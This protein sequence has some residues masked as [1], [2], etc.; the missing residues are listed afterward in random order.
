MGYIISSSADIAIYESGTFNIDTLKTSNE[1]DIK[2]EYYIDNVL[3]WSGFVVPNFFSR[4]IGTPAIV[5]MVASDR[6]GSLK[7]QTLSGLPAMV[8]LSS[9]VSSCLSK[10]VLSLPIN[11]KADFTSVVGNENVFASKVISQR[12]TDTKGRNISCY[13]ILRSILVMT[14]SVVVQRNGQWYVANKIQIE[15]GTAR[16]S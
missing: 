15:Q 14:N 6:L 3:T 12:F 9:L 10:T 13:D 4:V 11:L 2:V 7:G 5:N 8:T 1:T 16:V